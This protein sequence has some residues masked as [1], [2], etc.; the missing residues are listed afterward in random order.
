MKHFNDEAI[1]TAKE[2][3]LAMYAKLANLTPSE[4]FTLQDIEKTMFYLKDYISELESLEYNR[5][6]KAHNKG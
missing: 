4:K 2:G 6:R 3:S 5:S 1:K